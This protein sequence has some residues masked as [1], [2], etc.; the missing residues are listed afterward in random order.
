MKNEAGHF[1]QSQRTIKNGQYFCEDLLLL[2]RGCFAD[3]NADNT[4]FLF[5]FLCTFP[6]T[7]RRRS[8]SQSRGRWLILFFST[9]RPSCWQDLC[10][11]PRP[12]GST[13]FS[14]QTYSCVLPT[15]GLWTLNLQLSVDQVERK[16]RNV[17]SFFDEESRGGRRE[18]REK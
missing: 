17:D 11:L 4:F 9:A 14:C 1:S 13:G 8:S 5:F 6:T 7:S 3:S 10:Y 18:K 16:P 2:S 12:S 15:G